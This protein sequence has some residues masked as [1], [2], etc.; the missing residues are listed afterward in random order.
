MASHRER[1]QASAMAEDDKRGDDGV[2]G[3]RPD[4]A[5]PTPTHVYVSGHRAPMM[6]G[7]FGIPDVA[8]RCLFCGRRE[9][10]VAKLVSGRGA[11]ICDRCVRLAAEALDDPALGGNV[12][13]I[14]PPRVNP[15]NRDEAEDAIERAY[16]TVLVSDLSDPERAAA[17]ESGGNLVATMREVQARYPLRTR[18]DVTIEYVRFLDEDEAEVGFTL[19]MPGPAA[20]PGMQIPSRGYAVRQGGVW[21]MAR[22]TY[23]ELVGRLGVTVP[24]PDQ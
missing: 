8:R 13:R 11:Y 19:L 3:A 7:A 23:A 12:V 21:K 6:I 1:R 16:E 15:A 18:I 22:A 14:K 17:I 5:E 24:P 10:A 9:G 2:E 20:V 4:E